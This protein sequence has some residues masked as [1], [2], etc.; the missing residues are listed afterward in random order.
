MLEVVFA[1]WCMIGFIAYIAL[2]VIEYRQEGQVT[3]DYRDL[4]LLPMITLLGLI[5]WVIIAHE[6][7]WFRK[8]KF[9]YTFKRK[10]K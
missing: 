10:D 1:I 4:A 9:S 8:L 5:G 7:G 3:I 2:N 6:M